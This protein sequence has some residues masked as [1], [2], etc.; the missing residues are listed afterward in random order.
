ME[1]RERRAEE[2]FERKMKEIQSSET[3]STKL[4]RIAKLARQMANT[5]LTSLSHHIDMDW[6][7]EAWKRTRK[8]GTSGV[9]GVTARNYEADLEQSLQSLLDRA[10]SSRYFAPP[11]RRVEIPKGKG[12]RR[13]E[14][15]WWLASG[16][17]H[18]AFLRHA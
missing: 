5:P 17:R 1:E 2:L 16:D 15:I 8:S 3:V 18:P 7:G 10:K 12:A 9:D 6:M 4:E 11:V 14:H 13:H